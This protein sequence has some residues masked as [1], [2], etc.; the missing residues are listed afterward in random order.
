M[1]F[2][3]ANSCDS[4]PSLNIADILD[5]AAMK[6]DAVATRGAKRDFIDLY[7][8]SKSGY[9]LINLLN[10]YNKK[11]GKLGS[12][13]VHIHKSLVFFDDAEPDEMPRML[14][15]VKWEEVK[16]Y[17]ESEVKKLARIVTE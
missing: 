11:Y 12:N 4:H 9:A 17:F 6:I 7:F 1:D 3:I 16:N 14:K 8:I 2:L 5:I 15:E 10:F 13:L